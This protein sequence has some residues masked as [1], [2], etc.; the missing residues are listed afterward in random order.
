MFMGTALALLSLLS[1]LLFARMHI[2]SLQLASPNLLVFSLT[3]FSNLNV[4]FGKGFQAK[5]F[6]EILLCLLL[7]LFASGLIH[8]VCVR[9]CFTFFMVGLNYINKISS[10]SGNSSIPHTSQDHRV[11]AK[12]EADPKCP[13]K[14]EEGGKGRGEK[15]RGR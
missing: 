2:Y 9:T 8:Q 10:L 12:R 13:I 15:R 7:A 6:P 3:A 14:F 4:V 1:L 5:I 11:R